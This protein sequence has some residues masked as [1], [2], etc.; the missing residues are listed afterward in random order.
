MPTLTGFKFHFGLDGFML[1]MLVDVT[2]D[3]RKKF[4]TLSCNLL[5]AS[6]TLKMREWKHR[7]VNEYG[8]RGLTYVCPV[9]RT[10]L[11]YT[12]LRQ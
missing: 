9:D 10:A 2:S 3:S 5:A 11:I 7:E 6:G 8:K 4:S 12:L 1:R